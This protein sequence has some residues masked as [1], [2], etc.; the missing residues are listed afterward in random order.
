MLPVVSIFT[1]QF[2]GITGVLKTILDIV[3]SP[4]GDTV[5]F[6]VVDTSVVY[7]V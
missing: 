5:I 4:L 7:Q 2:K 3:N 6:P 1:A